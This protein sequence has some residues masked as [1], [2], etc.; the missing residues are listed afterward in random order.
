LDVA[1]TNGDFEPFMN[2]ISYYEKKEINRYLTILRQEKEK[3]E[4]DF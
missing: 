1:A 3:E 2:L 4:I